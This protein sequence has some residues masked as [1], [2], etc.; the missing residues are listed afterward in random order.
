[1]NVH[2][3]KCSCGKE[4]EDTEELQDHLDIHEI[5]PHD[6]H[7]ARKPTEDEIDALVAYFHDRG[8]C[9]E[10]VSHTVNAQYMV[11]ID[12]Y[13]TG[14]PG[15]AGKILLTVAE[16]TP[17]Y[18]TAFRWQDDGWVPLHQAE[19]IREMYQHL[20][21]RGPNDD[22]DECDHAEEHLVLSGSEEIATDEVHEVYRCES[23]GVRV[24]KVFEH[25]HNRIQNADGEFEEVEV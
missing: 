3:A 11:V 8:Y 12:G 23:C 7:K 16:A 21:E 17:S 19:E 9:A 1:M 18:Y 2:A 14:G 24:H 15:Y 10:E 13:I 6:Q 20:E 22:S 5:N 25:T 4:F